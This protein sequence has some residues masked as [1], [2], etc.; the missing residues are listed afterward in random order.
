MAFD[1]QKIVRKP[2]KKKVVQQKEIEKEIEEVFA[3][4]VLIPS[5]IRNGRTPQKISSSSVTTEEPVKKR[6]LRKMILPY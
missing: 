5:K 1:A 6:K 3:S 2:H 4:T